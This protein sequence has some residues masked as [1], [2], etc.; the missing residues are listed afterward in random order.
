MGLEKGKYL[1]LDMRN[2]FAGHILSTTGDAK[3]EGSRTLTQVLR[4]CLRL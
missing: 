4:G 3:L 1:N 2:I